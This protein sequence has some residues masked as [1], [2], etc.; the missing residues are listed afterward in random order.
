MNDHE[1]AAVVDASSYEALR[2][3]APDLVDEIRDLLGQGK[4]PEQI[5]RAIRRRFGDR[6][7]VRYCGHAARHLTQFR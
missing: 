4:T 3:F 1:L 6:D 2:V 7:L 5:G